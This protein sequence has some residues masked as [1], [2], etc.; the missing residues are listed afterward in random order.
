MD[1]NVGKAVFAMIGHPIGMECFEFALGPP[2]IL[3]SLM[4]LNFV[5]HQIRKC[6]PRRYN[7]RHWEATG[8][9]SGKFPIR[10]SPQSARASQRE[11]QDRK[12][13]K[14]LGTPRKP[15]AVLDDKGH[16]YRSEGPR[17][18]GQYCRQKSVQIGLSAALSRERKR[19]EAE[20]SCAIFAH[21]IS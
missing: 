13:E 17:W 18:N 6:A 16:G 10:Y 4:P 11:W 8:R 3:V 21:T 20:L 9:A 14:L 7:D 12:F 2:R 15:D 19:R 5:A 1:P